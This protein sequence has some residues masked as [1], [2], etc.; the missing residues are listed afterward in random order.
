MTQ[1]NFIFIIYID[2]HRKYTFGTLGT[3]LRFCIQM[4]S[5]I[6]PLFGCGAVQEV[7]DGDEEDEESVAG[8]QQLD[9]MWVQQCHQPPI[10]YGL[11]MFI[12]PIK[13]VIRGWFIIAI[14]T[15]HFVIDW[16][17]F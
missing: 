11:Y 2:L 10:F 4:C 12:P 14:P 16:L 17:P 5:Q 9:I 7:H 6:L 13:M 3:R 1:L 15:L 8:P